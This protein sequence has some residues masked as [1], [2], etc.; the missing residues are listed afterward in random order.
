MMAF[1]ATEAWMDNGWLRRLAMGLNVRR[2]SSAITA[3]LDEAIRMTSTTPPC[4]SW[5]ARSREDTISAI[6]SI[7]F[8]LAATTTL[9]VS[10]SALARTHSLA[11]TKTAGGASRSSRPRDA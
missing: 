10:V 2:S 3:E 9:L 11:S 7:R 1:E 8:R 4:D 5:P 6:L